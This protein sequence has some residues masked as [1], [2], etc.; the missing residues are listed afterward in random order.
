MTEEF[1]ESLKQTLKGTV[2]VTEQKPKATVGMRGLD[3]FTTGEKV[4]SAVAKLLS[5]P[6]VDAKVRLTAADAREQIRA[7]VD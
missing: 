6:Q 4:L 3:S 1:C 5:V 7:F 2:T